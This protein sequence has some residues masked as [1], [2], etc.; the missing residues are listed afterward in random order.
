MNP[1]EIEGR[2]EQ[3]FY[4]SSSCSIKG[5]NREKKKGLHQ[6]FRIGTASGEC[7]TRYVS[8]R[9]H[10]TPF[11]TSLLEIGQPWYG[12]RKPFPDT[13]TFET[14]DLIWPET[15]C[16]ISISWRIFLALSLNEGFEQGIIL[17]RLVNPADIVLKHSLRYLET[18]L[19]GSTITYTLF[20]MDVLR[21]LLRSVGKLI[22]ASE[23]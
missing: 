23:V 13:L 18:P 7:L 22:R 12:S 4:D 9:W 1:L 16:Y 17:P 10:R 6:I 15:L 5:W 2:R 11:N 21:R 20:Q 8:S 3:Q 19:L 14:K